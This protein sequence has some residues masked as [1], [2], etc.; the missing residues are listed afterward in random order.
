LVSDFSGLHQ[1]DTVPD[2]QSMRFCVQPP[3]RFIERFF[4]QIEGSPVHR[5]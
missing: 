4:G 5:E 1:P 2:G 3:C